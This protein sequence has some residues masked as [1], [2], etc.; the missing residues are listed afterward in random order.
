MLKTS[1]TESTEPK[2][3]VVAIGNSGREKHKGKAKPVNRHEVGGNEVDDEVDDKVG[4]NQKISKS[5]KMIGSLDFLIPEAKL[6]FTKLRQAFLK[7]L[8]LYH[9]NLKR[10]IWIET[11]V[12][13]YTISKI[14]S[15]LTLNDLGQWHLM[16]FFFWKIIPTKIRYKTHNDELLAIVEAFKI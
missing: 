15:Q 5:K 3:G 6:A 13:G 1:N 10:H 9:F 2:K 16:I 8:I 11:D 4:K 12:S 7:A 14:L